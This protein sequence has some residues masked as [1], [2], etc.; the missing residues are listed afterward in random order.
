MPSLRARAAR[1]EPLAAH[2]WG[3]PCVPRGPRLQDLLK[4]RV[5]SC[6]SLILNRTSSIM[7][8]QL[9]AQHCSA[10]TRRM[11]SSADG[12]WLAAARAHLL[13]STW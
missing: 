13:M 3:A 9:R 1:Q 8:P 5:W 4:A 6:S 10:G 7:G 11:G 2:A 12:P